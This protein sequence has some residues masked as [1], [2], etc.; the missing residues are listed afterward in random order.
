M[1]DAAYL[2]F[3][4]TSLYFDAVLT[5]QSEHT[6]SVVEHTVESGADI[7]DHVRDGNDRITLEVFVSNTPIEDVNGW[8]GG[9]VQG[10]A[11]DVPSSKKLPAPTPGALL[12]AAV[13]AATDLI[14]GKKAYKASVLKFPSKFNAPKDV[15]TQLE[16]WK[17]GAVLGKV[18]LPWKTVENVVITRVAAN[19]TAATG[20]AATFTIDLQQ[21]RLVETKLV[22]SP[23][24][25]EI[26]GKVA[27][28]K[29]KQP[30]TEKTTSEGK[31]SILRKLLGG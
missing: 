26:R 3:D 18:I 24:P 4:G 20:D 8:Y 14:A 25:T 30:T 2:E 31:K 28:S 12:N 13:A 16:A 22:T 1:S 9:S 29:G 11:L 19:R 6:A 5:E 15:L 21:I 7:S 17:K 27:I 10:V 23:V